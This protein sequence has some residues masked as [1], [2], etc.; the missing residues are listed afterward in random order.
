MSTCAS[1]GNW[2]FALNPPNLAEMGTA[3]DP[4]PRIIDS[5]RSYAI[6]VM[7]SDDVSKRVIAQVS[8]GDVSLLSIGR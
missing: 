6:C 7:S 5:L 1:N 2:T 3:D 4:V 8:V